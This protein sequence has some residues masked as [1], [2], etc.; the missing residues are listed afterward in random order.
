MTSTASAAGPRPAKRRRLAVRR[1]PEAGPSLEVILIENAT[2]RGRVEHAPMP[3]H[4]HDYHELIWIRRGIG[5]HLVDGER[6]EVGPHTLTLIRRGQV[7]VFERATDVD[8]A[9][10]RFGDELLYE[11]PARANPVWLV[12]ATGLGSLT[13]PHEEVGR[14]ES[15]VD[16][17]V[18]ETRRPFDARSVDLYRHLLFTLL[19]W[20]E[21]WYD[22]SRGR[23][24]S[25][26]DAEVELYRR[27]AQALE[28]D[29]IRHRSV[30]HYADALGV[31]P[32]VLARALSHTTGRTTKALI[33]ERVMLEAARL[34]RF[35]DMQVGEIAFRVGLGDQLYF[36]RA[37]KRQYGESPLAYRERLRGGAEASKR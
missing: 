4:R 35:T 16:A 17:L 33:M 24:P 7:H 2:A 32:A 23:G 19:L 11:G 10:I 36:S 25:G 6:F 26:D 9:V 29:F 18:A 30:G 21:R 8:A 20:A 22:G 28:Q 12:G 1:L 5:G 37:F 31:P 34:L 3:P 15:I 14:V 13:V 27:F